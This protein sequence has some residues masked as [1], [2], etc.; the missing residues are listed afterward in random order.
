MDKDRIFRLAARSFPASLRVLKPGA[1]ELVCKLARSVCYENADEAAKR[2]QLEA[3]MAA[4][5][6]TRTNRIDGYKTSEIHEVI[7]KTL[8][9]ENGRIADTSLASLACEEIYFYLC[10]INR[11]ARCNYDVGNDVRQQDAEEG[12]RREEAARKQEEERLAQQKDQQAQLDARLA[13]MTSVEKAIYRIREKDEAYEVYG[14]RGAYA[15][16][17]WHKIALALRD[18]WQST[19]KWDGKQSKKQADKNKTVS[20]A[21]EVE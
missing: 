6:K 17:D 15:P 8:R 2:V 1:I 11:M 5:R 9:L 19:G 4:L 12:Q 20:E 3:T 14:E 7:D 16:E 18:H 10:S 13:N 21:I